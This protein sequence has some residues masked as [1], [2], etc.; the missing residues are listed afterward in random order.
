[1]RPVPALGGWPSDSI[2]EAD[3]KRAAGPHA[4]AG[5]A[6]RHQDPAGQTGLSGICQ[7]AAPAR[8]ALPRLAQVRWDV[9]DE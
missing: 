2:F 9:E 3:D 1:M 6:R 7:V 5:M 8:L 4:D